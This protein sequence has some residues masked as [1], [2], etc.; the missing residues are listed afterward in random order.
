MPIHVDRYNIQCPLDKLRLGT[1]SSTCNGF[2]GSSDLSSVLEETG[3]AAAK[4]NNYIKKTY[5]MPY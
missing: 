5:K 1:A 2:D 4:E 3:R